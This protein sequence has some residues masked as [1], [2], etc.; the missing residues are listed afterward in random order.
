[1]ITDSEMESSDLTLPSTSFA[2][3]HDHSNNNSHSIPFHQISDDDDEIIHSSSPNPPFS[4][5]SIRLISRA[6]PSSLLCF[7][8]TLSFHLFLL[9]SLPLPL[10]SLF[11]SQTDTEE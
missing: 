9:R 4:F 8:L 1:M 3:D 2:F 6:L 11:P 7:C 10:V 5:N